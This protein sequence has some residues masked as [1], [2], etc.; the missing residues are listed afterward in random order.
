VIAPQRSFIL[1]V[2]ISSFGALFTWMMIFITHYYFR[3]MRERSG[4]AP[5][6][7]RMIGFPYTTLLGAGLMA[8][9]LIT[10]LFTPAFRLTLVFGAPFL[11]C[12][13]LV[14]RFRHRKRAA[15]SSVEAV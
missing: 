12:L 1:M 9:V 5:L 13:V 15:A 11:V 2:A 8:A 3:R 10:T 4:A 6:R 7:F 14:Y